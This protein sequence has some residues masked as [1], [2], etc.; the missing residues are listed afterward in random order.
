MNSATVKHEDHDIRLDKWFKRHFQH[1]SFIKIAKLIRKGTIR[2]NKKKVGIDHRISEGDIILY[3][4]FTE[5]PQDAKIRSNKRLEQELLNAVIYKDANIL[6]LNKPHGIAV[7]GGSKIKD[8]IDELS[9]CLQF[10]YDEKPK[11]VHRLDKDTTGVLLLARKTN[12]AAKLGEL[13]KSK[14]LKKTYLALV[15]GCPKPAMGKIDIPLEKS[16]H[17]KFEKMEKSSKG[18]KSITLYKV[19]D[20]AGHKYSLVE[21]ELVTGRTHQI[22]AHLS[23][24]DCPILGDEKYGNRAD[25]FKGIDKKLYLHSYKTDISLDGKKYTFVAP[26][27][28]YFKHALNTLGL[29][30]NN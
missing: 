9:H 27:P 10:E 23:M 25:L 6:V 20:H 28:N 26:L 15:K 12:I 7:Q 30:D 5:T 2:V 19:L 8:S 3:P 11:L 21:L 14:Q 24:I 4:T 1:I 13:F 18:A 22:R 17:S 29:S 16:L